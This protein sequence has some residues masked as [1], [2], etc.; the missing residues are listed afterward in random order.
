V[1]ERTDNFKAELAALCR[2][3]H[4]EISAEDHYQGYA[5]CGEDIRMT[6]EFDSDSTVDPYV[7]Y[8][9]LDL[10]KYFDGKEKP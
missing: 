5:E 2:K 9:D 8:E 10:G 4:C 1:S 3:Y 7:P 6:V